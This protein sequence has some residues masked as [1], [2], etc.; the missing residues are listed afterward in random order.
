MRESLL[1]AEHASGLTYGGIEG[2]AVEMAK[3]SL[4]DGLGVIL[5]ASTLGEGCEAFVSMALST[6]GKGESTVIGFGDKVPSFMAA[7]ANGSM[8]H[9]LDFEDTHDEAKVHPNAASIPAALAVAEAVGGVSGKEL[10]TALVLGSD[11]TVRLGLAL[12]RDPIAYGWYMPPILNAF[13]AAAAAGKLL[14]LNPRQFLDAFSLALCQATCSAELVHSPHTVIRAVRD[15]FSAKAGVMSALLAQKGVAGFERPMEGPAGLFRL[16]ARD[17]FDLSRMVRGLGETFEGA[18]VSYK[19]WPCCRGTH[20]YLEAALKLIGTHGIDPSDIDT[21]KI[22]IS[23]DPLQKALCEP[24]ERKR[25]PGTAIDAKFSIP[26]VVATALAHGEVRLKHFVGEALQDGKVLA[27]AERVTLKADSRF[28]EGRG[29]IEVGSKGRIFLEETPEYVYGHPLRPMGMDD[30]V[31]KFIDCAA[32]S[33]IRI[34]PE[35][36]QKWTGAVLSLEEQDNVTKVIRGIHK[37]FEPE[38]GKGT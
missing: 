7:F 11:L 21:V 25:K 26:F 32:Y 24:L 9:A 28:P 2:K 3:R 18:N 34:P 4:I 27:M 8:A 23:P 1:I 29:A 5:A 38:V 22:I 30:L 10:I 35:A 14:N 12:K 20:P 37:S 16:Y 6:G 13:G 36:A 33:R 31:K 17:E 19:P 15:A